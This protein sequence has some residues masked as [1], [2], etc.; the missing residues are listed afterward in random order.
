LDELNFLDSLE[1]LLGQQAQ[2]QQRR[3][4]QTG[5]GNLG[6]GNMNRAAASKSERGLYAPISEASGQQR[7]SMIPQPPRSRMG[8]S[9]FN[10]EGGGDKNQ[11]QQLHRDVGSIRTAVASASA[12]HS[13]RQDPAILLSGGGAPPM[14]QA[15]QRFSSARAAPAAAAGSSVRKPPGAAVAAGRRADGVSG[16]GGLTEPPAAAR[17]IAAKDRN[18]K[19]GTQKSAPGG[20]QRGSGATSDNTSIKAIM[21]QRHEERPRDTA[22]ADDENIKAMANQIASDPAFKEFTKELSESLGSLSKAMRRGD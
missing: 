2:Q 5:L 4:Q 16:E 17:S 21:E 11:R 1:Q 7:P 3:Q 15:K 22:L 20:R 6:A 12:R 14:P 18:T 19:I 10:L 9:F 8:G 13:R